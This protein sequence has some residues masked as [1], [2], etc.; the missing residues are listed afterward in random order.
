MTWLKSDDGMGEHPKTWRLIRRRKYVGLAA[1]GLHDLAR[2]HASRYFTDGHVPAEFVDDV[3][4]RAGLRPKEVPA[5][6]DALVA[7]GQWTVDE[8]DGWWIHDYLDH[9]PS[10]AQ[11]EEQRRKDRERKAA[12]GRNGKPGGFQADSARNPNGVR[13]ESESPVPSR[14]TPVP[15]T[16]DVVVLRDVD[17]R[18]RDVGP[19]AEWGVAP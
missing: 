11:V 4:E 16:T 13:A 9:N 2:L 1:F 14:P 18:P 7:S 6:T 12:G 15:S 10:R 17:A 19:D 8:S 3:C 5:M